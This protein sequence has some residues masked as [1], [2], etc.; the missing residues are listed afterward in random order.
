MPP[1]LLAALALPRRHTLHTPLGQSQPRL[2]HAIQAS[3][4]EAPQPNWGATQAEISLA[5]EEYVRR[6]INR[7][8]AQCIRLQWA[9]DTLHTRLLLAQRCDADGETAY[10]QIA[11]EQDLRP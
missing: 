6:E 11:A 1:G 4:A 9:H 7:N 5:S 10:S 2:A 8:A 3:L